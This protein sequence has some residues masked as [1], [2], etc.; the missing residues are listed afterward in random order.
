LPLKEHLL[1]ILAGLLRRSD[2]LED[3]ILAILQSAPESLGQLAPRMDVA[4]GLAAVAME[5][6]QSFRVLVGVGLV[7]SAIC[8]MRPQFEALTRSVWAMFAASDADIERMH[9]HL[10]LESEKAAGKLP[11]L[12]KMLAEIAEK[13]PAGPAQMLASFKESSLVSLNS[14]VHGGLHVLHRQVEGHPEVLV[15]QIV[16]NSNG[17]QTMAGML[18]AMLSGSQATASR[19]SKIQPAFADCLPELVRG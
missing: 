19:M 18:L 15:A 8:L 1:T 2:E 13:A 6:G 5:H 7:T 3:E 12:S 11:M 17:L 4:V 14:Y 9:A 10:T 16:R